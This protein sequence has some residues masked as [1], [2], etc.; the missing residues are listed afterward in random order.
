MLARLG[1]GFRQI[2]RRT[3]AA[4]ERPA[5]GAFHRE[6]CRAPP[7]LAT[8]A[9]RQQGPQARRRLARDDEAE[10]NQL[11]QRLLDL[12]SQQPAAL[13]KLVEK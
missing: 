11:G 3:R 2:V 10:R 8:G 13:D 7:P 12:R 4:R 5:P 1:R 9:R 6:T